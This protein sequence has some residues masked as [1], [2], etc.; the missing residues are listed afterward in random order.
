MLAAKTPETYINKPGAINEAGGQI[1]RIGK[2][3]LIIGG[4]TALE[5]VG[6]LFQ[7]LENV[8]IE[9]S[10][11]YTFDG[12]PSET[13][14]QKYVNIA[15]HAGA[16]VVIGI[17]GGRAIDTAK[18][19]AD[20]LGI[21]AVAIP[22]IAAT[23]AAWAAVTI[24][25]DDEGAYVQGRWNKH[26]P[27]LVI[28]D[29]EVIFT[30]PERYLF[31]GVADTFAKL[32]ETTPALERCPDNASLALA[33]HA[34]RIAFDKLEQQT[35][36]ALAQAKQGEYGQAARDVIDAVIYLAGFAGS[37]QEEGLPHYG[38]A[39]PFYHVSTRL[40]G[41]RHKLHGEKVA[42]GIVAQLF[43]E[44]KPE[45]E[46]IRTIQ[47]FNKYNAAFTLEDIGIGSDEEDIRFIE[48]DVRD[49][50]PYVAYSGEEIAEAL[51]A[52]D[53]LTKRALVGR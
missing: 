45:K 33:V 50:F 7:S 43:L 2:R 49:A 53:A 47:L 37:F 20:I 35:F 41:T 18:A 16:D 30:A 42:Y 51:L 10:D 24:Q 27:R 44:K 31:S 26:S 25:Y 46:I 36:R 52:A 38:F 3:P 4:K 9:S 32:Y 14:F 11:T 1:A 21:P 48:K 39:H 34:S 22:T 8:G 13:Q 5:R 23:C 40:G 29:P 28:A 17:G 19:V 15:K 6:G 12:Y